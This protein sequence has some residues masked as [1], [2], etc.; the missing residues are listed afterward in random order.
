MKNHAT[1]AAWIA[2]LYLLFFILS[3]GLS[4][5]QPFIMLLFSLSPVVVIWMVYRVL[6]MGEPSKKKFE[7]DWYDFN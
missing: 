2:T 3:I 1:E 5:P 6:V 7:D 4:L